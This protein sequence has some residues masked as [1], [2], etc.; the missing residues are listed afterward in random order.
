MKVVGLLMGH[1]DND[2]IQLVLDDLSKY[3]DE[4]YVNLND[5]TD[6][7]KEAVTN[8]PKVVKI[9]E[10]T[11]DGH[12]W[13]QAIVRDKTL[14]MLDEVKPDIVLFPD[15]DEVYPDT[16]PEILK[17]FIE[18][19]NEC[20]WFNLMY[21]W[22]KPNQVRRDGLFKSMHHVRAFK[23]RPGLTFLPQCGYGAKPTNTESVGYRFH[24]SAPIKHYGYMTEANRIKK[25]T[26]WG[27]K[28][29]LDKEYRDKTI[30]DIKIINI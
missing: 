12:P 14:R 19:P 30:K 16:M 10:T 22:D 20:L 28:K 1:E 3:V 7:I 4:I 25:Y 2:Y 29:Y 6:V 23:W 9:I 11:N 8:C 17:E 21:V 5:A 13:N 27:N 24:A 15:S 18:S 26:R